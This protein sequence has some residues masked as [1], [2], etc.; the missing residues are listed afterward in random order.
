MGGGGTHKH[1]QHKNMPEQ[2]ERK[3]YGNTNILHRQL[4][5]LHDGTKTHSMQMQGC[6]FVFRKYF[7]QI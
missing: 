6:Q 4:A 5:L 3:T 1:T 7:K 2:K